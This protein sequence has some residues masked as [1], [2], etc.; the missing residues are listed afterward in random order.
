MNGSNSMFTVADKTTSTSEGPSPVVNVFQHHSVDCHKADPMYDRL[1][2][3]TQSDQSHTSPCEFSNHFWQT[4][5]HPL[6]LTS[7]SHFV[8]FETAFLPIII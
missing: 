7:L 2:N 8:E 6:Q 1:M 5:T 4:L 3:R